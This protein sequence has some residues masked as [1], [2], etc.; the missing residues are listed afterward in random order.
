MVRTFTSIYLSEEPLP[1]L[2]NFA[3]YRARPGRAAAEV[4]PALQGLFLEE[5]H[6]L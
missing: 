2:G 5:L 1:P 6:P 4:L 3:I